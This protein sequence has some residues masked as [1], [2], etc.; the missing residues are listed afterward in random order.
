VKSSHARRTFVNRRT[1]LV[2]AML[3]AMQAGVVHAVEVTLRN[4][5]MR[6]APAGAASA[7]AYV[8]IVSDTA[9]VLAGASTPMASKVEI[10]LVKRLGDPESEEVVTSLAVLAGA[11]TRLAYLGDHLR[12][13]GVTRDVA[14]GD[15]V[16]LTL[17]FKDTA[18]RP[19]KATTNVV[20]RGVLLPQHMA[21]E[22]RDAPS[23]PVAPA[24][25]P[26][27]SDA[28]RM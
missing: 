19:V 9:L 18:G 3:G 4:A 28:P 15:L 5:W 16:P 8:D 22:S 12:I 21:P 14:N 25:T 6:P 13:V 10:V 17:T 24:P 20:V 1:V 2:L 23:P 27:A 7:R 26:A 11:T